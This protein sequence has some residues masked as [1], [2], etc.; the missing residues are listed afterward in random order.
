M[1]ILVTGGAGY[2]GSTLVRVLIEEG[3]DVKVIDNLTY[4]GE[5]IKN[6]DI[7]LIKGDIRSSRDITRAVKGVDAIIN[8]AAIVGDPCGR[9]FPD[10]TISINY[11]ALRK[12]IEVSKKEGVSRIIHASTCSVYGFNDEIC[13][14]TTTPNPLSLYAMTKVL[15]EHLLKNQE[16]VDWTI[17]RLGTVFGLSYRMRFDLV[18]N[19]LIAKAL[20]NKK[21]TVYGR[22]TQYR[23][24]VHVK[25]ASNTFLELLDKDWAINEI[26]NVV[27]FNKSVEDIAKEIQCEVPDSEI[28]YVDEK[29]DNRSYRASSKKLVEKGVRPK[30]TIKDAVK[31]IRAAFEERVITNYGAKKY[32]NYKT[33]STL[34]NK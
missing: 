8:L 34:L 21:I 6:L 28:V 15:G 18:L 31:E 17:L 1:K 13:T 12:L 25:D 26:F 11:A 7:E 20:V 2:I 27:A 5:S 16:G 4:G 19:L 32:N 23:P 3:Y 33:L 24:F 9:S 14:E 30:R 29:E 22:G 10:E